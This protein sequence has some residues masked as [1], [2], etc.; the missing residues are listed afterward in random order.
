MVRYQAQ[1]IPAEAEDEV[2]DLFMAKPTRT[3]QEQAMTQVAERHQSRGEGTSPTERDRRESDRPSRGT[4]IPG[5][6]P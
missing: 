3:Q 2:P 4:A 5:E 6:G 1:S